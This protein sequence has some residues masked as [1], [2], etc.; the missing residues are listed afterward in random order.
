MSR[1]KLK[2]FKKRQNLAEADRDWKFFMIADF[3]DDED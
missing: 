1:S 2:E 3:L